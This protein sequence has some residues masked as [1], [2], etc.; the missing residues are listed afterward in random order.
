[1]RLNRFLASA[2]IGSRR[3]CE[4]LI[5]EGKVRINSHPVTDLATQVT[6][7]DRVTVSGKPVKP[8]AKQTLIVYKP[9]GLITSSADE[10]GRRTVID[11]L[12]AHFGRL[13]H[14]GRLDKESE[15]LLVLTNDGDLAQLLTHPS[16][17]VEKEYEVVLDKPFDAAHRDKLL[18][19]F[20]II[21][22]R[23]RMD[24]VHIVAPNKLRVVL[25]QGIKRQIRLMLGTYGYEVKKLE[26][27]RIGGLRDR[28]IKPGQWRLLDARELR[29]LCTPA[30]A[31][32]TARKTPVPSARPR[33][34]TGAA[35]V[36]RPP[37]IIRPKRD[38]RSGG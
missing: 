26:R 10:R 23:A 2:G 21:G 20:H 25:T 27:T 38:I 30:R 12:P 19:G 6:P 31:A 16:S 9:A 3:G 29:M 17:H 4:A 22:G 13:F 35:I 14:V 36:R 5:L 34:S 37:K 24:S 15:G 7:D 11:L 33:R 8:Q 18:A 32:E 1:M 28:Q